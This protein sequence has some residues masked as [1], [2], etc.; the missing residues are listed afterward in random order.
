MKNQEIEQFVRAE[1][2]EVMPNMIW[3][4][5]NG[6]YEVFGRYI[7]SKVSSHLYEVN[8][9]ATCVGRF[10][11]T[12]TALS[13][14]IADKYKNYNLAREILTVDN[15][16]GNLTNDIFI[17]AA[18]ANKTKKTQFREDIETKLETKIIRKRELETQLDKCVKRA[19]YLQQRGFNN[20]TSRPGRATTNKTS[21]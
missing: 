9:H 7:I 16:L 1:L 6:D 10:N 20:E 14:C 17:R 3:R 21:R 19:K 13:W 4:D 5:E 15:I 2:K 18:M 12:K 11:S 8:I